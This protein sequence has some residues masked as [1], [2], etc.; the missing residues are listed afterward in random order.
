MAMT[1]ARGA[2]ATRAR[3]RATTI[4]EKKRDGETTRARGRARTRASADGSEAREKT[5]GRRAAIGVAAIALHG[6]KRNAARAEEE[7]AATGTAT[8]T[9][10]GT[11]NALDAYEMA[12]RSG[13]NSNAAK[14][15]VNKGEKKSKVK[16]E[17]KE[18]SSGPPGALLGA[19]PVV[20]GLGGFLS[21]IH[22]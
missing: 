3:A 18:G 6:G 10:R 4:G 17:A 12:T 7:A 8:A 13:G 16:I 20:L 15:I 5:M 11:A 21:L 19:I 22:I 1:T 2:T 14:A 9:P